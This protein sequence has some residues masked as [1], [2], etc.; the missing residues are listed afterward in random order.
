M[1]KFQICSMTAGSQLHITIH[2]L[3]GLCDER[4]SIAVIKH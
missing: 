2:N 3:L 4:V 1:R